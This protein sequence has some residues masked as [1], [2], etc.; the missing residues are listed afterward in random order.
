M[1]AGSAYTESKESD[2]DLNSIADFT[3]G[4]I[5]GAVDR[6]EL[7]GGRTTTIPLREG[8][9]AAKTNALVESAPLSPSIPSSTLLSV[10]HAISVE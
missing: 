4:G 7:Y 2:K 8:E 1:A 9:G 5:G 10:T 6:R 3:G